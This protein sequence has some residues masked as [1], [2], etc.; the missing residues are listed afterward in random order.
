MF[1]TRVVAAS[2]PKMPKCLVM[3]RRIMVLPPPSLA[4]AANS[5]GHKWTILLVATVTFC[6]SH[7]LAG[8]ECPDMSMSTAASNQKLEAMMMYSVGGCVY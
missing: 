8:K 5:G 3:A 7:P 4:E 6:S 1:K 2:T